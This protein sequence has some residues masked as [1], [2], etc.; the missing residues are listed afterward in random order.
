MIPVNEPKLTGNEKK[1]LNECIESGWISSEGP[2][3]SKFE[4]LY[5]TFIGVENG[6]AV[7]NGTAALESALYGVGIK[8]GDEVILTSFTIMSCA[9]A[10]IR[11]GAKPVFVDIEPHQWNMDVTQIEGL[12]TAKT[13]AIMVVHIY[14]HPVDMDPI[15]NLK[16]KYN[17]AIVEDFAEAQGSE[18]FSE[19]NKKWFK[20][21]SM[22]DVSAVSFYAN[23]IVTTGEGGMVL[24]NNANIMERVLSY[25]NLCFD[26][27]QRFLHTDLGFNFR[28]TNLQAAVGVA[29][30]EQIDAFIKIKT[31]LGEYYRLRLNEIPWLRFMSSQKWAKVVYWMYCIEINSNVGFTA[32][33]LGEWLNKNQIGF[34]TFFKGLHSQKV[35]KKYFDGR[36]FP[37][38]ENAFQNGLYLPSG[39]TMNK[40]KIDQV[41]EVLKRFKN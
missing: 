38:S 27:K 34:R 1:Y 4:K 12:I 32:K 21:G 10:C 16:E 2:F 31:N 17:L 3:V 19:K 20:C 24:T 8:K 29:Q 18:Y 15:L 40:E 26:P 37:N 22:G 41:I 5:S 11:L 36:K 14:G 7:C 39:M 6:I 33:E 23:K 30:L 9:L 13:K 35:L 25:R 28:M